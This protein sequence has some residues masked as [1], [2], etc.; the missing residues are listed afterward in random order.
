MS[1]AMQPAMQPSLAPQVRN[2]LSCPSQA[3]ANVIKELAHNA[4]VVAEL[5]GGTR[6]LIRKRFET[7]GD[8][9]K[10]RYETD[11]V[12]L[13]ATEN[14]GILTPWR[15]LRKTRPE[16]WEAHNKD[17]LQKW[18]R[19]KQEERSREERGDSP[20]DRAGSMWDFWIPLCIFSWA[21]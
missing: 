4:K 2:L 8:I 18:E 5:P 7:T 19:E 14:M 16:Y 17:V 15:E 9:K 1:S 12:T 13:D 21:D 10:E 6:F 3:H 11:E 20:E